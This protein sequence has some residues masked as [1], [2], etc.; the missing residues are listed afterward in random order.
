MVAVAEGYAEIRDAGEGNRR[1]LG[2]SGFPVALT[3]SFWS[4]LPPYGEAKVS[5]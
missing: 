4:K 5:L 1:S 2:V 3:K